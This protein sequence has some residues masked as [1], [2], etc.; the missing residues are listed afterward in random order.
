MKINKE[1]IEA[2]VALPDDALWREI[3]KIAAGY[4][5]ALP[6]ATPS[7]GDLEKLRGAVSGSRLNMSDALR[8]LNNYRRGCGR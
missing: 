5:I 6:E 2:M 8:V 1:Q 7:H 3:V 4:G